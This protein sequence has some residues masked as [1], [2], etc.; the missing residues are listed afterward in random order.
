MRTIYIRNLFRGYWKKK[1]LII[2]GLIVFVLI[3]GYIGLRRAYPE[4]MDASLAAEIEE[5]NEQ[6]ATYDEAI[7]EYQENLETA[8]A[9]LAAEQEYVENSLYMQIDPEEVQKASVQYILTV[10]DA[11]S[12]SEENNLLTSDINAMKAYVEDGSF[13]SE[14]TERLD[15]EGSNYWSELIE[16]SSTGKAVTLS[17]IHYDMEQAEEILAEAI[18]LVEAYKPTV[19]ENFGE[20]TMTSQGISTQV[21]ADSAV[22]TAQNKEMTNLRT[23]R[24]NVADLRTK[25]ATQRTNRKNYIEQYQPTGTSSSPRRTLLEFGAVGVIAGIIVPLL[26]Y[27]VYYTLSNR[28]K[29][30]EELQAAGI[31]VIAYYRPKKGYVPSLDKAVVNLLLLKQKNQADRISLCTLGESAALEQVEKDLT[32]ALADKDLDVCVTQQGAEDAESLEKQSEI[33]NHLMLVEAGRTT[34]TQLEEQIQFCE[35]LNINIWGCIVVE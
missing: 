1:W 7:A 25:L 32:E 16:L 23:Y 34:Y 17:V 28:I 22:L 2:V 13:M 26:I 4:R 18:D 35:S 9:E 19:E 14:L 20:F 5:Y 27:A 31:S 11:P 8:E 24:T 29:G 3:F 15:L 10:P 21:Y 30:K 33:G 6:V 12:T